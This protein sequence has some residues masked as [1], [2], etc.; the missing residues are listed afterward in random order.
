LCIEYHEEECLYREKVYTD[1][2]LVSDSDWM[3]KMVKA[4]S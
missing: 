4:C 2:K 1:G 3:E